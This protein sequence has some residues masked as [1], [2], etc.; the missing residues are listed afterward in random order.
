MSTKSLG[1]LKWEEVHK[2]FAEKHQS[3]EAQIT[4]F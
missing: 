2:Y 1:S 3:V 4:A